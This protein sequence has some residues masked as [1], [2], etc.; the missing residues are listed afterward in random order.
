[1]PFSNLTVSGIVKLAEEL[2][3]HKYKPNPVRI[4]RVTKANKKFRHLGCFN[5][6]DKVVQQALYMIL[7]SFYELSFLKESH[8]FRPGK[9]TY[10]CVDQMKKTWKKITWFLKF[11]IQKYFDRVSYKNFMCLV[12]CKIRDTATCNLISKLF[13]SGYN[14]GWPNGLIDFNL[15]TEYKT[16]QNS[17]ISPL[18]RNV[19]FH[20]LDLYV[21]EIL[22]PLHTRYKSIKYLEDSIWIYIREIIS[23]V[24]F[25]AKKRPVK[26]FIRQ[27]RVKQAVH[28]SIFYKEDRRLRF[29]RYADDFVL[30]FLGRKKDAFHV[31]QLIIHFLFSL[32]LKINIEKTKISHHSK[33]IFFLG[34]NVRGSYKTNDVKKINNVKVEISYV[35]FKFIILTKQLLECF[36]TKEFIRVPKKGKS[37]ERLVARRVDKW[38]MLESDA[39]VIDR[40]NSIMLGLSDYYFSFSYKYNLWMVYRLLKISSALTLAHRHRLHRSAKAFKLW[41]NCLSIEK[42]TRKSNTKVISLLIP[43]FKTDAR[44]NI[45]KF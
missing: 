40:F 45:Q 17:I 5:S 28:A 18:I 4:V 31:L 44:F 27:Y 6:R 36:K 30:G 19:F 10:T 8:S 39:Y 22:I 9:S 12:V 11:D 13:K 24:V 15:T 38:L 20:E 21:R 29:V 1:M 7:S 41:G 25:L 34:Y 42:K 35:N 37:Q 16:L 26:K 23:G 43:R 14:S 2:N 33:G 32:G 3:N